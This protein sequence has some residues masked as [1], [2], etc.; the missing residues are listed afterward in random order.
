MQSPNSSNDD[1]ETRKTGPQTETDVQRLY[2]S[3]ETTRNTRSHEAKG[4]RER[5]AK[6][7]E[8]RA[9]NEKEGGED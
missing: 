3:A 2:S 1:E 8:W 6:E 9:K 5:K 4:G 7:K